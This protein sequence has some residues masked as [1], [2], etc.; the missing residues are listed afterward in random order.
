MCYKN[1]GPRCS[2]H[3]HQLFLK[4]KNEYE[5][6]PNEE[7]LDKARK[8]WL[9]YLKTPAGFKELEKQMQSEDAMT[10]ISAASQLEINKIER[11][12]ALRALKVQEDEGEPVYYPKKFVDHALNSSL[13]WEGE[14]P[15]WWESYQDEARN[16]V[17][18][19]EPELLDV[20]DTPAGKVAVIWDEV[21]NSARDK[22][23]ILENGMSISRL[24]FRTFDT[25]E[26]VAYITVAQMSDESYQR[27]FKNDFISPL[28]RKWAFSMGR[29]SD[30]NETLEEEYRRA[31]LVAHRLDRVSIQRDGKQ[32]ASYELNEEHLPEDMDQIKQD[33]QTFVDAYGP[34]NQRC[35]DYYRTPYVDYSH[36][37]NPNL[38]GM[39]IGATAYVYTARKLATQGKVLRG[40]SI[41]SD[42]AQAAWRNMKKNLPD[43]VGTITLVAPH[44]E[45]INVCPTLDFR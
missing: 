4:Y 22:Y 7:N 38:K 12:R 32:I 34:E 25:N 24:T 44:T 18:P 9:E 26:K 19:S 10:R 8:A 36:V 20:I 17:I 41:Q 15:S 39:G 45:E 40:S 14:K 5:N 30:P 42:E 1:P 29:D 21:S 37:S 2:H 33:L 13:R 31:W 6:N 27:S 43:N 16:Y 35:R 23:V 3:A 28:R 11:S